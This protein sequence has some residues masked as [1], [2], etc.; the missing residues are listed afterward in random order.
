MRFI[1]RICRR[2]LYHLLIDVDG[3]LFLIVPV[4]LAFLGEF[5]FEL[6][7]DLLFLLAD[8]PSE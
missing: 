3:R 1:E 6:L 7:D 8:S 5:L 2:R 4:F